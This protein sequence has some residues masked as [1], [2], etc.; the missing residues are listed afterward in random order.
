MVTNPLK[1]LFGHSPIKPIQQ[2]MAVVV[3]C[4]EQVPSL[5][6]ALFDNN[7]KGVQDTRDRIFAL[8]EQAD[9]L[10]NAMRSHLPKSLLMPVN[11]G[12]L[13]ELLHMQD[14]I[15]G[16]AQDIAGF[17]TTRTMPAIGELK[18]PILSLAS[19][20]AEA[21]KQAGTIVGL[22]DEL[23]ETGF[24]GRESNRVSELVEELSKTESDTDQLAINAV[25]AVFTNE[26]KMGAA[27]VVF[28]YELIKWT[29]NLGDNAEHVGNR[30]RLLI[31][32]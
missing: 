22:L 28:W 26:D 6:E 11:R 23:V 8:E 19:R 16:V 27:D 31:A 20:C 21:C 13:L 5:F 25:K 10:K 32:R 9:G 1:N 14:N 4:A 3:Q 12:D 17:L 2:H 30:L 24:T 18:A 7:A 15:A 29:A